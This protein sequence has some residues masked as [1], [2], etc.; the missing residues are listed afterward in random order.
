V[1]ER[2][3]GVRGAAPSFLA[4]ARFAVETSATKRKLILVGQRRRFPMRAADHVPLIYDLCG[5]FRRFSSAD[6][7]DKVSFIERKHL[8]E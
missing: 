7:R 2:G 8:S 3:A 5:I 6:K 4:V 1:V